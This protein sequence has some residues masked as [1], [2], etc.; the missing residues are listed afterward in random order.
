[1]VVSEV[2]SH[3]LLD[4]NFMLA[5]PIKYKGLMKL[6]ENDKPIELINSPDHYDGGSFEAIDVIEAFDLDFN[7]G[8][9]IKYILRADKKG[10][11]KQDLQK[12]QWY[13]NRELEKWKG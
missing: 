1:M 8:N 4:K 6:S 2:S 5:G 9:V 10:N 7:L 12:A 11:R 13:L 3:S